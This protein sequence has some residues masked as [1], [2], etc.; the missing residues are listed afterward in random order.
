MH[1]PR[2][3]ARRSTNTTSASVQLTKGRRDG[4]RSAAS[5]PPLPSEHNT[6]V[7]VRPCPD[8]GFSP[9]AVI[10]C[11]ADRYQV[12]CGLGRGSGCRGRGGRQRVRRLGRGDGRRVHWRRVSATGRRTPSCSRPRLAGGSPLD[13]AAR[14]GCCQS[15][16]DRCGSA[17]ALRSR[18]CRTG[19][20]ITELGQD[21]APV[22]AARPG[23]L[24]MIWAAGAAGR[25]DRSPSADLGGIAAASSRFTIAE[26]VAP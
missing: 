3:A 12:S 13:G 23:K 24:V 20:A 7:Q 22:R 21:S 17:R 9:N 2:S 8:P 25:R 14:G 4:R 10:R 6:G 26:A 11:S 5:S 16:G 19:G 1:Q 15:P 18:G